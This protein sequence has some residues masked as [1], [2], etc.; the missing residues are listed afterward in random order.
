MGELWVDTDLGFDDIHALLL[1][2]CHGIKPV[3]HSL[4]FG[5]ATLDKVIGNAHGVEQ[6]FDFGSRWHSGA[7]TALD[8]QCRT[9]SHILGENGMLS[10]GLTLPGNE[11]NG[12]ALLQKDTAVQ[13]MVNWLNSH[14]DKP[15]ILALGP[16]TNLAQLIRKAPELAATVSQ[17]T[18]MGG[19][20]GRGNQTVYAEFNAWADPHAAA[21]V[22]SSGIRVHMVEL[23][24]C[25]KLQLLPQDVEQLSGVQTPLA[26]LLQDLLGGYLDIG[27]SRGRSG[28][29]LYDPL[30]AAAVI[31][32]NDILGSLPVQ[33]SVETTDSEQAGR[34]HISA[35]GDSTENVHSLCVINDASAVHELIIDALIHTAT[36]E[37]ELP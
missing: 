27:L 12:N 8:G 14:P 1:L 7:A 10:R 3:A 25:R 23:E 11:S 15:H 37:R 4:V 32:D 24:A 16:L 35:V 29:A 31:L 26:R 34:T 30:A 20:A 36:G 5:C 9:A 33:I 6:A 17:I 19:S 2:H 22:M 13:A 28:M 18:W 21:I